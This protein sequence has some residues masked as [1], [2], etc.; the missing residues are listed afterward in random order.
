MFV[1]KSVAADSLRTRPCNI[2][3]LP[4]EILHLL[5]EQVASGGGTNIG[6]MRGT[7]TDSLR[8]QCLLNDATQ[9]MVHIGE[10]I[11]RCLGGTSSVW[12]GVEYRVTII[13]S[14][15]LCKLIRLAGKFSGLAMRL[16]ELF[17]GHPRLYQSVIELMWRTLLSFD[18][19]NY[20]VVCYI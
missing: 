15:I 10:D 7:W 17:C 19:P 3:D 5:F 4:D 2:C 9:P 18:I 12:S 14:Y 1:M 11:M 20:L 8:V 16:K 6:L 13:L